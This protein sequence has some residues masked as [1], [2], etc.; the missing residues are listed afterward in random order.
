MGTRSSSKTI[1][2]IF[3]NFSKFDHSV[4]KINYYITSFQGK[5]IPRN[6]VFKIKIQSEVKSKSRWLNNNLVVLFI[7]ITSV[8][9]Q[10]PRVARKPFGKRPPQNNNNNIFIVVNQSII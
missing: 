5:K 10:E 2:L 7:L 4:Y 8:P 1:E 6:F 3:D 9:L